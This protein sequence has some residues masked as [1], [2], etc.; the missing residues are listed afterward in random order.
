MPATLYYCPEIKSQTIWN[1]NVE[2]TPETVTFTTSISSAVGTMA[3]QPWSDAGG[4]T[5][6][7]WSSLKD[8]MDY[9]GFDRWIVPMDFNLRHQ[10]VINVFAETLV[11]RWDTR[12]WAE[13][14]PGRIAPCHVITR[15]EDKSFL[16]SYVQVFAPPRATVTANV[17]LLTPERVIR[18]MGRKPYWPMMKVTEGA[19]NDEQIEINVE[20]LP[21]ANVELYLT[22]DK[23]HV[24]RKIKLV[25]GTASFPFTTT[26]MTAGDEAVIGVGFRLFVNAEKI[27]VRR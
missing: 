22:A 20:M 9:C 13:Q 7:L 17:P 10:P 21:S 24:P 27:T 14:V 1:V 4:T 19:R 25:N 5:T 6:I 11:N 18:K 26:G 15:P 2:V 3:G 16:D 8:R 23:G 12:E